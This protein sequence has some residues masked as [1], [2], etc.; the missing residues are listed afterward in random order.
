MD[1][2]QRI[3]SAYIQ[4]NGFIFSAGDAL[5][6]KTALIAA[7]LYNVDGLFPSLIKAA[8]FRAAGPGVP[9]LPRLHKPAGLVDMSQGNIVHT[10]LFNI[11]KADGIIV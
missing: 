8:P 10:A 5:C 3:Q 1:S 9:G 4:L 2:Q 7:E 11:V 6:L